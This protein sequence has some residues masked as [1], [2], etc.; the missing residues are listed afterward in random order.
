MGFLDTFVGAVGKNLAG[1]TGPAGMA[2]AGLGSAALSGSET[3][4]KTADDLKKRV[5]EGLSG[6]AESAYKPLTEFATLFAV[7]TGLVILALIGV[8][9]V[10]RK[11]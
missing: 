7:N 6:A 9:L 4:K 5:Q 3:V 10:V 8:W 1:A 2:A 11:A